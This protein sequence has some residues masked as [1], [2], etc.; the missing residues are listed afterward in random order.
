MELTDP[1]IGTIFELAQR[2]RPPLVAV[3]DLVQLAM[4]KLEDVKEL[5]AAGL[6]FFKIDDER[7][8]AR[9][10][11]NPRDFLLAARIVGD[12]R[13]EAIFAAA[14]ALPMVH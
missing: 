2:P 14:V 7:A 4:M 10:W 8:Y 3:A 11:V 5:R 6:E 9:A 1:V 12:Q 13:A